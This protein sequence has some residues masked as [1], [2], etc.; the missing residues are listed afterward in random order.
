M[1]FGAGQA[2]YFTALYAMPPGECY[3]FIK[4]FDYI[5][6]VVR[7]LPP[8]VTYCESVFRKSFIENVEVFLLEG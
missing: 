8:D 2:C 1:S 5:C 6:L 7:F 4:T 3:P